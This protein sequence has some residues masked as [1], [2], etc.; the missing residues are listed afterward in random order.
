MDAQLDFDPEEDVK[1]SSGSG[2][3]EESSD[4]D[5]VGTE[6]YEKVGYVVH[7]FIFSLDVKLTM[8]VGRAD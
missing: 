6:H 5:N 4:D 1:Y 7:C 3:E 2:S 8:I